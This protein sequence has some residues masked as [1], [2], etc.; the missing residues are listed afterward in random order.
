MKNLENLYVSGKVSWTEESLDPNSLTYL[1]NNAV[2]KHETQT[3]GFPVA[4]EKLVKIKSLQLKDKDSSSVFQKIKEV[5]DDAVQQNPDSDSI[6]IR[7]TKIFRNILVMDDLEVYNNLEVKKINGF[8]V[9][10]VVSQIFQKYHDSSIVS[11]QI[12]FVEP[13]KINHL[14]TNSSIHGVMLD[15]IAQVDKRMPEYM[16]FKHLVVERDISLYKLDGVN[17]EDLTKN[18]VTLDADHEIAGDFT[19]DGPVVVI[20]TYTHYFSIKFNKF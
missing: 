15:N 20:G 2:T 6:S 5:I 1:I 10:Q 3:I 12:T 14:F 13:V 17:F 7:G 16:F 19:F 4:F 11:S 9:D 8:D 18:R